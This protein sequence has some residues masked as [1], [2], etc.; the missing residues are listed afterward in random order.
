MLDMIFGVT[1]LPL[2]GQVHRGLRGVGRLLASRPI[3]G[4]QLSF[5]GPL[6]LTVVVVIRDSSRCRFLPASAVVQSDGITLFYASASSE[7]EIL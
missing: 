6:L 2:T 3:T 1:T 4:E 5:C 7:F